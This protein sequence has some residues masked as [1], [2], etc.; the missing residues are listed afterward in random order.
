[1]NFWPPLLVAAGG[2]RLAR[3]PVADCLCL[4]PL[5]LVMCQRCGET[6]PGRARQPCPAHPGD[7]YLLD[8]VACVACGQRDVTRLQ[9][10]PLPAGME[11][12]MVKRNILLRT[13]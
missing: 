1:M 7:L 2:G 6:F 8:C 11:Q 10:F 5:K 3:Q 13:A 12:E 9:E 4:R